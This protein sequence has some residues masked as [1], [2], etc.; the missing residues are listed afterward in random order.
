[1][2]T[3]LSAEVPS[4]LSPHA[5]APLT[6]HG[7]HLAQAEGKSTFNFDVTMVEDAMQNDPDG[8]DTVRR[9]RAWVRSRRILFSDVAGT[10]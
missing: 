1:M 7:S 9:G 5:W 10:A 2:H 4:M 8:P 6:R 3:F